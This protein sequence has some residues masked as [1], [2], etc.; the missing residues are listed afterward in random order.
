MCLLRA[1]S[2][3]SRY[4][5]SRR[6]DRGVI[7]RKYLL[8][9]YSEYDANYMTHV[10]EDCIYVEEW[11]KGDEV[12]RRIIYELEE[13]TPYLGNPFEQ[14]KLPWSWIGDITTD[15]DITMAVDPYL[16]PGN[17]IHLDLLLLFLRAH[18]DMEIRYTHPASGQ[19]LLFPN[20]G[21]RIEAD[22]TA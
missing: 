22:G 13:I 9:E 15:V 18:N 8:G 4:L 21:V 17:E 3:L 7:S 1:F 19:H 12:R 6:T 14:I 2:A 16:M 11:V 10:P 5:A 20:N